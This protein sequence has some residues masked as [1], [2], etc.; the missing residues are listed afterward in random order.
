MQLLVGGGDD[1]LFGKKI[2]KKILVLPI[3]AAV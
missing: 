3:K 2:L 1:H